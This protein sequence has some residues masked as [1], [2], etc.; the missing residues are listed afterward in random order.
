V[1]VSDAAGLAALN[2]LLRNPE[3]H[4][5]N[6]HSTLYPGGAVRAPLAE[7]NANKPAVSAVLSAVNDTSMRVVAPG[8]LMTVF[9][10]NL[11]KVS[12]DPGGNPVAGSVPLSINGTKLSLGGKDAPLMVVR[13][14]HV[15]AQVPVDVAPG[16]HPLN[17]TNAN[18]DAAVPFSVTVAAA[19]PAIYFDGTG[20][21]V[22][23][24][25]DFFL[26]RPGNPA[27][28]G[29]ILV[30]YSTGLGLTTPALATGQIVPYPP[31]SL[32]AAVTVTIG[33][34]SAPVIYSIASPG[35]LGL[36]QTAVRMPVGV[37]PGNAR[38]V[39]S[40]AGASSNSVSLAVQ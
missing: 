24:N 8:G 30:I 35:F 25:S 29:D 36:Y 9:G 2:S 7:P 6:L 15:V 17:A 14:D 26:V 37:P 39:L 33:G 4:Y 19:A 12:M 20:G 16:T 11:S 5:V 1:T 22:V 13:P 32:T 34:Q 27:R 31:A 10:T 38:L 23:K 21:L 3:N 18:G 28:A 40:I